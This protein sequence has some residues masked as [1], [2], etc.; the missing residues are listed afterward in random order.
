LEKATAKLGAKLGRP[1]EAG[2]T[3]EPELVEYA[4]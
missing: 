4:E 3:G 1:D 2:G